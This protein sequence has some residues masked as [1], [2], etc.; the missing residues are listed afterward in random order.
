M[1]QLQQPPAYMNGADF[2]AFV[3]KQFDRNRGLLEKA[4]LLA[5]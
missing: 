5:E 3:K 4:G 1:D 2:E